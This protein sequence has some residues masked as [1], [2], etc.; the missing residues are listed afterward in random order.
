MK[1]WIDE[2]KIVGTKV[3]TNLGQ[4]WNVEVSDL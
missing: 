3:G 1:A 2:T 4:V